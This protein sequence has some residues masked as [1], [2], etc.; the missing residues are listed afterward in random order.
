MRIP[1]VELAVEAPFWQASE[2]V[3]PTGVFGLR[4]WVLPL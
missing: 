3:I 2:G 1:A 4:I